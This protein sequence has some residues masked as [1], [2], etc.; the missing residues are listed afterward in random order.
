MN[1]PL[2]II[3]IWFFVSLL[4]A[5]NEHGKPKE[6]IHNFWISFLNFIITTILII[7]LNN[8]VVIP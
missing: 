3:Y 1:W 6:G 2:L 8:W 7:W 4:I 5:A